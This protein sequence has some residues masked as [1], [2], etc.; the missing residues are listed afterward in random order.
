MENIG[1]E[2]DGVENSSNEKEKLI[3]HHSNEK[4]EDGNEEDYYRIAIS[5]AQ[6]NRG[7]YTHKSAF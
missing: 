3:S 2:D 5:A 6:F 7:K 1:Q 4:G